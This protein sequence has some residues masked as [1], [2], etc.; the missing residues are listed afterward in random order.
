MAF[1]SAFEHLQDSNL[2]V[3]DLLALL[4][5]FFPNNIVYID[6][7][8]SPFL[9]NV[10]LLIILAGN[11]PKRTSIYGGIISLEPHLLPKFLR[12]DTKFV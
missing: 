11:I 6:L 4:L 7:N 1:I 3:E 5:L 10:G 2:I 8:G 12:V 9:R